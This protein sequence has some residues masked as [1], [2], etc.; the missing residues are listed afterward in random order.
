MVGDIWIWCLVGRARTFVTPGWFSVK[1]ER[2]CGEK[3][4]GRKTRLDLLKLAQ[5]TEELFINHCHS[6][7]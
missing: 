1:A 7:S 4:R 3:Q 6:V 5:T 2:V